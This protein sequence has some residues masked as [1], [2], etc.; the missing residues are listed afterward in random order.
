MSELI[1]AWALAHHRW[2]MVN[3]PA[4]AVVMFLLFWDF[5]FVPDWEHW[6]YLTCRLSFYSRYFELC[7]LGFNQFP[8]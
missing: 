6:C 5:M 4:K 8:S 2:S 1:A 7:K 3:G